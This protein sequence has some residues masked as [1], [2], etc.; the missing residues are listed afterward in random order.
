MDKR[1]R[2]RAKL[3]VTCY[4]YRIFDTQNLYLSSVNNI[5]CLRNQILQELINNK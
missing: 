2:A 4:E 5:L 1:P 3:S